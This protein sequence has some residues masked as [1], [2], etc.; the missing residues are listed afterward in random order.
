MTG[1]PQS[2]ASC[3]SGQR[4][5]LPT[6]HTCGQSSTGSENLSTHTICPLTSLFWKQLQGRSARQCPTCS[7]SSALRQTGAFEGRV[8]SC[9]YQVCSSPIYARWVQVGFF[10]RTKKQKMTDSPLGFRLLTHFPKLKAG[11]VC[12]LL[13][14]EVSFSREKLYHV[15]KFVGF[16]IYLFSSLAGYA[17]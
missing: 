17:H 9:E 16:L 12:P 15:L 13:A 5:V 6:P 11:K 4:S 3:P 2:S 1:M 7:R 8:A 14:R 10:D